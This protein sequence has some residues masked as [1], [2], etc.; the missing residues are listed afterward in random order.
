VFAFSCRF[1][2]MQELG[3]DVSKGCGERLGEEDEEK[4]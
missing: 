1:K 4:N 3:L 2:G